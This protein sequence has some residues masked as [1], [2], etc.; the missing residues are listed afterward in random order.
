MVKCHL[1]CGPHISFIYIFYLSIQHTVQPS[2][3]STCSFLEKYYG[4]DLPFRNCML[5]SNIPKISSTSDGV[6]ILL[7]IAVSLVAKFKLLQSTVVVS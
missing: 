1:A 3:L 4:L 6:E 5:K 2:N 7:H